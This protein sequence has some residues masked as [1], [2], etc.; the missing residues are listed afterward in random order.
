[1]RRKERNRNKKE[2]KKEKEE[3]FTIS[4]S[5]SAE[6]NYD[7][8]KTDDCI[9]HPLSF[10]FF[11]FFF[12]PFLSLSFS[13]FPSPRFSGSV[14]MVTHSLIQRKRMREKKKERKRKKEGFFPLN[15][16]Q[17]KESEWERR[18]ERRRKK[19]KEGE[20]RRKKMRTS[21]EADEHDLR[22]TTWF[23]S[24]SQLVLFERR[25]DSFF[26]SLFLSLILFLPLSEFH[27]LAL[28]NR[29]EREKKE[30]GERKI[31]RERERVERGRRK[32]KRNLINFVP[33]TLYIMV[34]SGLEIELSFRYS[35]FK[36]LC[37]VDHGQRPAL[38]DS[39]YFFLLFPRVGWR[40]F[41]D[42]RSLG[43]RGRIPCDA[44]SRLPQRLFKNSR[45]R[46]EGQL[47]N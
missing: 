3:G 15:P 5:L 14:W 25:I 44:P 38:R 36:S 4:S 30:R 6:G 31:E 27:L 37:H 17:G 23:S 24:F 26:L 13:S 40:R 8:T 47:K 41:S 20:R 43:S 1:M 42:A 12:S 7:V 39:F 46:G 45:S 34:L 22:Q 2:R 18:R 16:I 10:F 11:S 21:L 35:P 9:S 19:E 33:F 29:K 32:R 28:K